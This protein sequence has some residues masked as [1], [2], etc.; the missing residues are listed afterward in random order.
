M[1]N[2]A[3]YVRVS[4]DEQAREGYSIDAQIKAIKD[5]A[6][7]N[8]I[9]IDNQYIFKDEGISGRK[10][11]KR[12]AFMEMIKLAKSKPKKFDIILVH[13]FDRFSR[14]RED[15]VVYKSLLRKEYGINIISIC[16]PLDPDDKMSVI[17]EAFLEAMAE[18]YSLNLSEEVKKG[19]L[20][21][22]EEG[23][24]QT[25]PCYGYDVL[26]KENILVI[27]EK[28]SKIVK[29]IFEK[30][31]IDHIP[32]LTIA[33]ELSKM[34]IKNK[35]GNKFENRSLCY[36]LNNPTYIGKLRYTPGRRNTYDFDDPNTILV[37]GKHE[38]IISLDLWNAAQIEMAKNRKWRKPKQTINSNPK[39]WISGL[40]RCKECGCTMVSYNKSK[41]RC[42]GYQKGKCTNKEVLD[43]NEIKNILIEK[44]KEDLS[45]DIINN[46]TIKEN[47][48]NKIIS[49]FDIIN[50]NLNLIKEK[51][52]RIKDAYISGIDTL[53]EYQEN[54]KMLEDEEKE[55]QIRLSKLDKP[56]LNNQKNEIIEN[57]K[58]IYQLLIDD[59]ISESKKYIMA[60]QLFDRIEYDRNTNYLEIYYNE[61]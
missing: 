61:Q 39:Y 45:N 2:G 4:T 8:N 11:E 30:Y 52:K 41:L 25:R 44:L 7:K 17:L 38:P 57:G 49:E 48:H 22:H 15:S 60:H 26:E 59:K 3:I 23:G 42:N 51:E 10:A 35:K 50:D 27:N 43:P 32:M 13:K 9:F 47:K 56:D 19:Q 18:Y 53:K 16:E 36:I 28:E 29:Y 55:L 1:K 5:Y 46:I 33:R 24:L 54:K 34:G 21:K 14:N 37:D 6:L 12:P 31:A 40:V 20:E 58:K